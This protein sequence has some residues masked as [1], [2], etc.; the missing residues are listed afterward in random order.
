[1]LVNLFM[2]AWCGFVDRF[3]SLKRLD[4]SIDACVSAKTCPKCRNENSRRR[5]VFQ[6]IGAFADKQ[7]HFVALYWDA[8]VQWDASHADRSRKVSETGAK[9]HERLHLELALC[10]ELPVKHSGTSPIQPILLET[11]AV[12]AF[13]HLWV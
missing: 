3:K 5:K 12:I 2:L 10:Y 1:M 7:I 8:F 11:F 9:K 4:W 6:Q 13:E